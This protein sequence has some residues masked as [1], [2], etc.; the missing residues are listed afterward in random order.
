MK[1]KN[2][3]NIVIASNTPIGQ[4]IKMQENLSEKCSVVNIIPKIKG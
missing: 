2:E 4:L 1:I 3:V